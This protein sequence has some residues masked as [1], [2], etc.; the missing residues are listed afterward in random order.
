MPNFTAVLWN[1][2]LR[3]LQREKVHTAEP[4]QSSWTWSIFRTKTFNFSIFLGPVKVGNIRPKAILHTKKKK[5]QYHSWNWQIFIGSH[6]NSSLLSFCYLPL[7]IYH[8]RKNKKFC[9]ICYVNGLSPRP[10][11]SS[12][13]VDSKKRRKWRPSFDTVLVYHSFLINS[14]LT[15]P[16]QRW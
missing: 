6:L 11:S 1:L 16:A 3:L 5:S 14:Q 2:K 4:A 13:S 9:Q 8:A 10:Q 7:I 12:I 15:I